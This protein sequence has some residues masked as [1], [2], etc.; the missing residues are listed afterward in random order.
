M[1]MNKNKVIAKKVTFQHKCNHT[2]HTKTYRTFSAK[3]RNRIIQ[4]RVRK[5]RQQILRRKLKIENNAEVRRISRGT[6]APELT[7]KVFIPAS[8]YTSF[9]RDQSKNSPRATGNK[10]LLSISQ[11]NEDQTKRSREIHM[12]VG[13]KINTSELFAV[14]QVTSRLRER[15][16]NIIKA[17]DSIRRVSCRV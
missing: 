1:E 14:Y 10:N 16:S 3:I 4:E 11:K 17:F 2:N 15:S 5:F 13:V 6:Q 9:Q 12:P 7:P 8:V